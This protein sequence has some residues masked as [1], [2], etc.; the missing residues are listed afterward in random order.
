[1]TPSEKRAE[2]DE[3]YT[4]K[5]EI[6]K[7]AYESRPGGKEN[8]FTEQIDDSYWEKLRNLTKKEQVDDLIGQQLPHTATLINDITISAE[9]LRSVT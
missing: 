1:M 4:E 8:P 9:K 6:A 3:L 2:L 7:E 5:T